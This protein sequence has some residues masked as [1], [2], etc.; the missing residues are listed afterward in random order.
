M[1][2][3]DGTEL[4]DADRARKRYL[5][6]ERQARDGMSK[7]HGFLDPEA[8]ATLEAVL[9]KLAAPGKCNPDDESPCVDGQPSHAHIQGD[10]R[11]QGQRNH[12]ALTAM[13]RAILASGKLGRLNG[14][15]CTVIVSH[16]KNYLVDE[17]D[18]EADDG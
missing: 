8:R 10:L 6:L 7:I 15:P 2:D 4:T 18:D 16:P 13:G 9:A 3:Q 1:I 14:L 11:A 5:S 12:D 17:K